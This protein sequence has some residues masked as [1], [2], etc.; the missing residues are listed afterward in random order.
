MRLALSVKKM[1]G[2]QRVVVGRGDPLLPGHGREGRF[3]ETRIDSRGFR[4]SS[5]KSLP[6]EV[7][8]LVKSCS[9][10]FGKAGIALLFYGTNSPPK[11]KSVSRVTL[12]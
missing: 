9:K 3:Q 1:I 8:A 6:T 7:P 10:N 5:T 2:F 4:N 11:M 12:G